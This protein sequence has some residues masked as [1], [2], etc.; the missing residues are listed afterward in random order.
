MARRK[1]L[2]VTC[3]VCS[4]VFYLETWAEQLPEHT[5]GRGEA[6]LCSGSRRAEYLPT[7]N[8]AMAAQLEWAAGRAPEPRARQARRKESGASKVVAARK[9][10]EKRL[11]TRISKA[12]SELSQL[13]QKGNELQRQRADSDDRDALDLLTE[14]ENLLRTERRL[15]TEI[16]RAEKQLEKLAT[17]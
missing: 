10:E 5:I 7:S 17:D 3:A 12:G 1:G 2:R 13:M 8:E 4:R 14:H 16:A 11:Q 6:P 9:A 15:R